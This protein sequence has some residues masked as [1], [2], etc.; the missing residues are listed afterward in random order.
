M[1]EFTCYNGSMFVSELS[2]LIYA[3]DDFLDQTGLSYC[4]IKSI[5]NVA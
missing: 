3:I 4:D 5:V 1:W 2:T